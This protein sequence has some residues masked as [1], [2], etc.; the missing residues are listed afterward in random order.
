MAIAAKKPAAFNHAE[1]PAT[2]TRQRQRARFEAAANRKPSIKHFGPDQALGM[3]AAIATFRKAERPAALPP[4]VPVQAVLPMHSDD[5][6]RI[7]LGP[8]PIDVSTPRGGIS[9]QR[10]RLVEVLADIGRDDY[11]YAPWMELVTA[12]VAETSSDTV[13]FI[14]LD[15]GHLAA[16]RADLRDEKTWGQDEAWAVAVLIDDEVYRWVYQGPLSRLR[17]YVL[18]GVTRSRL[19]QAGALGLA[20]RGVPLRIERVKLHQAAPAAIAPEAPP[21][22]PSAKDAAR[23]LVAQGD[24][25]AELCQLAYKGRLL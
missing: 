5:W 20:E 14:D 6:E 7:D 9:T 19:E 21:A 3:K 2:R 15:E 24:V 25:R 16:L 17:R 4:V 13:V 10:A 11:R 18:D 22:E 1:D 23:A 8:L 12:S